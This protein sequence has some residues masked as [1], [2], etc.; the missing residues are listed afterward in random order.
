LN[1]LVDRFAE[2][3][4]WRVPAL[5]A[6]DRFLEVHSNAINRIALAV[7]WALLLLAWKGVDGRRMADAFI[8]LG[9]VFALLLVHSLIVL[10]RSQSRGADG[11]R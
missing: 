1:G 7:L 11:S 2:E 9:V 5:H 8:V 3:Y 4:D 6:V 10:D